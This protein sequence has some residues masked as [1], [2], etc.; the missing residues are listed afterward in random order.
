MW[1]SSLLCSFV[2]CKEN[3]VLWIQQHGPYHIGN[4]RKVLR[5]CSKIVISLPATNVGVFNRRGGHDE[6]EQSL[7]AMTPWCLQPLTSWTWRDIISFFQ[8]FK[9]QFF[10]AQNPKKYI[11]FKNDSA[12]C[13]EAQ[14]CHS[15]LLQKTRT[16][17]FLAW[18]LKPFWLDA[19][20]QD[21]LS[22]SPSLSKYP[23]PLSLLSFSEAFENEK[24]CMAWTAFYR[25]ALPWVRM[26][27]TFN[28]IKS[29]TRSDNKRTFTYRGI[30]LNEEKKTFLFVKNAI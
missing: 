30:F 15:F 17:F 9:K 3:N 13:S 12:Y 23:L 18:C 2:S 19:L 20:R 25:R 14:H 16:V 8:T 1:H 11:F 6:E 5:P 24:H 21:L 22:L 28:S 10:L 27:H 29:A 4:R 26:E 7:L